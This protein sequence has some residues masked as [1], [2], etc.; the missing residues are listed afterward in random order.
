MARSVIPTPRTRLPQR[1]RQ[2]HQQDHRS[3]EQRPVLQ[4]PLEGPR[5]GEPPSTPEAN[6][7]SSE[8]TEPTGR[9]V[10]VIDFFI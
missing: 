10:A 7:P 3:I 2:N 9:G 8:P 6:E 1:T 4:L 5:W